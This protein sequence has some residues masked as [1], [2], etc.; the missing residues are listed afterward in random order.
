[1]HL[2][3]CSNIILSIEKKNEYFIFPLPACLGSRLP[4]RSCFLH[5]EPWG[6]TRL[7]NVSET[8]LDRHTEGTVSE[9]FHVLWAD[10]HQHKLENPSH[11][12]ENKAA[13]EVT[14][15]WKTKWEDVGIHSPSSLQPLAGAFQRGCHKHQM[16]SH[17]VAAQRLNTR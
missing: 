8:L 16:F 5:L 12:R 11:S 2:R 10:V 17:A 3:L 7:R 1:M 6:L 4:S 14:D 13:D 9:L 15:D